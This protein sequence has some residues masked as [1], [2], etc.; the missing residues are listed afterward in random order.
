[1]D[2]G[3]TQPIE[4]EDERLTLGGYAARPPGRGNLGCCCW[5]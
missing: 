2:K 5:A 1:M 4:S 3:T